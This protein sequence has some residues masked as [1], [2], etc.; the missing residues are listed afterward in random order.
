[1][2]PLYFCG[3]SSPGLHTPDYINC[4]SFLHYLF[5]LPIVFLLLRDKKKKTSMK[6]S[7]EFRIRIEITSLCGSPWPARCLGS[8]IFILLTQ[9]NTPISQLT[10]C[11]FKA[12]SDITKPDL[13]APVIWICLWKVD[14]SMLWHWI[15][16]PHVL[17]WKKD[18]FVY[19]LR[20]RRDGRKTEWQITCVLKDCKSCSRAH[21]LWTAK[22]ELP[23][24]GTSKKGV[25]PRKWWDV[26]S[27]LYFVLF[28]VWA[29]CPQDR[30]ERS[31]GLSDGLGMR[32][33]SKGSISARRSGGKFLI[34]TTWLKEKGKNQNHA[35]NVGHSQG[36]KGR[37]IKI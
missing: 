18:V 36:W 2:E 31:L 11:W 12:A 6:K 1:M 30:R 5:L 4:F 28:G 33:K 3:N 32:Q 27:V 23:L 13:E 16:P 37:W 9:L 7:S 25:F 17:V 34:K 10:L 22:A 26:L 35:W 21:L 14:D 15:P 24:G 29:G 20:G 8:S 19:S